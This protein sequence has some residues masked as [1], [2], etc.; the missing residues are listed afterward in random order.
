[1]KKSVMVLG[2]IIVSMFMVSV[3]ANAEL[4]SFTDTHK[5]W[6]GW[7]NNSSDDSQDTIGIPNFTGGQATVTGDHLA[8][9]TI[10]RAAGKSP[11]WSVLSPGDLFIDVSGDKNWDY[12]VDLTSWSSSGANVSKAGPG[13]YNIYSIN[14]GLNDKN[15]AYIL[16]GK[17]DKN[18]W[19]GYYIR[20]C[21]PVAANI[22]GQPNGS[23]YFSGWGN[24][25]TT[26]YSF[27]FNGL[28]L[29]HSGQFTIGWEPN[30]ANDVIYETLHYSPTPEPATLSLLGLGLFGFLRLKRTIRRA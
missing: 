5:Y 19:K 18:G 21:H 20:D 15:G 29:G 17:D 28:D 14:L 25:S 10:N 4:I 11:Y 27:D 13:N 24:D 3:N 8:N 1:M 6:P 16:S 22:S 26:Q 23:V 9:I 2:L 12:V 7:G 30:C